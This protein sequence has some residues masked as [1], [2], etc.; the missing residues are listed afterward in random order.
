MTADRWHYT[1]DRWHY[2]CSHSAANIG[3]RGLLMPT[4]QI[5]LGYVRL[6]WFTDQ[7]DPDRDAL[8]LTSHHLP[9]DR[10]EQRYRAT[11]TIAI[12]TW[13]AWKAANRPDPIAVANLENGRNPDH[14]YVAS[15]PVLVEL[16][17][18]YTRP[19]TSPDLR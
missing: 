9:C 17:R 18:S 19:P 11:T 8:G 1:A 15:V 5:T 10:L 7:A 14:W 4:P 6:V 2:T 3:R 12:N 13:R 16:D